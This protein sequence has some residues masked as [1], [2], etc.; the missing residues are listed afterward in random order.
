MVAFYSVFDQICEVGY[1]F[2][3]AQK[4]HSLLEL[5]DCSHGHFLINLIREKAGTLV[6]GALSRVVAPS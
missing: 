3:F 1:S 2:I 4:T 5:A 6:L